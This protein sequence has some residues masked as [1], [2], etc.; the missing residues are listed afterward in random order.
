MDVAKYIS[1]SIWTYRPN[2]DNILTQVPRAACV[3]GW[4]GSLRGLLEAE[5]MIYELITSANIITAILFTAVFILV[6]HLTSRPRGIPPGPRGIPLLGNL[7]SLHGQ[8]S[9]KVFQQLRKQYGDVFSIYFGSQLVIVIN[10][11]ESIKNAF[12]RRGDDFSSRPHNF[13]TDELSKNLG[14]HSLQC[15]E[16]K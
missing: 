4:R 14:K 11:F 3:T 5:N 12:V 9:K 6:R 1:A 15:G 10:G 8:D 13:L 2:P 7:L 16:R